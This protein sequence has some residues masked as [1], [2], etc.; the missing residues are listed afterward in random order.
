MPKVK[1]EQIIRSFSE[2]VMYFVSNG[3][4]LTRKHCA[5]GLGL[6]NLTGMKQPIV[7]LLD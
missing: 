4:F 7:Y 2:D 3:N 6:H 1:K 5:T